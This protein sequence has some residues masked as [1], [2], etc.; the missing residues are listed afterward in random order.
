MRKILFI[1]VWYRLSDWYVYTEAL[2]GNLSSGIGDKA[3]INTGGIG[4]ESVEYHHLLNT[5]LLEPVINQPQLEPYNIG[6]VKDNDSK[7]H[8]SK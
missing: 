6:L 4:D 1:Y 2:E 5:I 8:W 7:L 3:V